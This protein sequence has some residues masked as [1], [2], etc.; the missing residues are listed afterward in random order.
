MS[1]TTDMVKLGI[2]SMCCASCETIMVFST[3]QPFGGLPNLLACPIIL[4]DGFNCEGTLRG[5]K[6]SIS[7]TEQLKFYRDF[8]QVLLDGKVVL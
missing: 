1:N 8:G 5:I 7:Q 3:K 2:G 6:K 4:D